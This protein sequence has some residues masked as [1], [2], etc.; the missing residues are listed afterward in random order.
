MHKI[1]VRYADEQGR[2]REEVFETRSLS[3]LRAAFNTKGYYILSESFEQGSLAERLRDAFTFRQGV[4]V[5][6]LNEFTKLLRTLLRSGMPITDALDVLLD[7]AEDTQLNMALR[8]VNKDI[9]EG[10]AL[11]AALGRHSDVFPDIYIK[12]IVAGEKAGALENILKRLT[13]YFA[14]SI[15]VKRKVVAALIYPAVLLAVS[16]LAVAYM[17]VAVVPEFAGLFRSLG[18]PLPLMTSL[19]L[20]SSEF[21]GEWFW[22]IIFALMLLVG[23]LISFSKSPDGRQKIDA[24]KLKLPLIRDL[25]KNFAYSQFSRTMATMVEGGIPIMD[26]LAVVIDSMENRVIAMRLAVL[27]ELL[28]K[29]MGFGNALKSIPDT[30]KMMVRV[31]MVGEESGNLGEMLENMADHY[32]EEISELT[33]MITS[34]IEPILFLAMALVVGTIVIALLYPVLTAASQIN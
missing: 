2:T 19:L 20:S 15:A 34:L 24:V 30:P 26:S 32:D 17:I 9:R 25:E 18:A 5:K 14:S 10:V 31:I 6:E 1:K 7:D 4:S 28:E 21:L 11:S 3:E 16:T 23:G 22:L 13:E 27:P 29:G 8:Q 12:T 33:D